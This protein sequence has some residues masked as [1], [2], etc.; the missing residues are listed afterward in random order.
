MAHDILISYSSKDKPT[1]DAV[2]A[3]LESTGIRCWI[4][5]RNVSAGQNHG[6]SIVG[7]IKGARVMVLVFPPMPITRPKLRSE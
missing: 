2:C 3:V 7:A 6:E 4:A 1:A 5:P